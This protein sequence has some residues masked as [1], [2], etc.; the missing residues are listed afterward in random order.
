MPETILPALGHIVAAS[1]AACGFAAWTFFALAQVYIQFFVPE[2]KT[3]PSIFPPRVARAIFTT[4]VT[5]F[6]AT[7]GLLL[8]AVA[9]ALGY[10]RYWAW[11]GVA[12]NGAFWVSLGALLIYSR[13]SD[14]KGS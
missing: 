14:R 12:T 1:A 6:I 11:I 8:A 4:L 10:S 2:K 3:K 9:L 7:V 13:K 5:A